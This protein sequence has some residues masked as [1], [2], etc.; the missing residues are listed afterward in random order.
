VATDL[1]TLRNEVRAR[2]GNR[3]TTALSDARIDFAL[4]ASINQI[5]SP[6]VHRHA[7]LERFVTVPTVATVDTVS[8]GLT[9]WT[10]FSL[11]CT[12][13]ANVRRMIGIGPQEMDEIEK[14]PGPPREYCRWGDQTN[15]T[16][17]ELNPIPDAVY[18]LK[19]RVYIYPQY[20]LDGSGLLSST[21]PV[22]EV[23]DEGVLL[24]AE[25]RVWMNDL[26]NPDRGMLVKNQ[27]ADWMETIISPYEGELD[28]QANDMMAPMLL[29]YSR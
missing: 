9:A 3:S 4:R 22:R 27:L 16:T 25:Y 18:T 6:K 1:S 28:D 7:D 24:G 14:A 20:T 17:L 8:L 11:R 12:T 15:G 10:I 13:T 5:A 2:V 21:C 19:A 26:Q 29:G 23:Y